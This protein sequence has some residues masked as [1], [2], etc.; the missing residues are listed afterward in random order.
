MSFYARIEGEIK[1]T[2]HKEFYKLYRTLRKGFWLDEHG[3]FLDEGG[4]RFSD[5]PDV[6]FQQ[7]S[8]RIPH[9]S[10]RNLA[11]LNF[12]SSDSVGKI[13]G[14]SCDGCFVG[15]ITTPYQDK[16]Y[17]LT[18]WAEEHS[19]EEMPD[20]ET[21]FDSYCEWQCEVENEFFDWANET[22]RV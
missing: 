7:C 5:E 19:D 16:H 3:Y 18:E 14:T 22:Q 1:Y 12:F 2:N 11:H 21:D 17:D 13:I 10:H 20:P 4:S 9:A 15:W 6:I 8:I